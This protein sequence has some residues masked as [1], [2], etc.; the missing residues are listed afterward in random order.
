MSLR[1]RYLWLVGGLVVAGLTA[2]AQ[3]P[4]LRLYEEFHA[5]SALPLLPSVTAT[6][7]DIAEGGPSDDLGKQVLLLRRPG[8]RP[9]QVSSETEYLY[10]SNI[11]LLET[12]PI[13]DDLLSETVQASYSPQLAD[14]LQSTFYAKY[15]LLRYDHNSSL[16]FEANAVGLSLSRPA[17]NWF[18][19]YGRFEAV[20]LYLTD[21]DDE[22]FKMFDTT[23]GL[24]RGQTVGQW[25][26]LFY[27]YQLDWRPSSPSQFTRVDNAGY[28]G[29]K[30]M[31]TDKLTIQLLY[32]I[33]AEEYLQVNR[34]DLNHLISLSVGYD[35][36]NYV[37]VRA[38]AEYGRNNSDATGFD[39][40]VFTGGG[41]LKLSVKF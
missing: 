15:Q 35:F 17:Q 9:F 2:R 12:H 41:G 21:G 4:Q 14:R 13:A 36:N 20:R 40:N 30:V 38:F 19:A 6:N 37:G 29:I 39:Y 11:L 27:G 5:P 1:C 10:D 24:W 33:R 3:E 26:W 8:P 32:R 23:V 16:D 25:G 22:F 28:V 7:V 34:A 31:P 18:T